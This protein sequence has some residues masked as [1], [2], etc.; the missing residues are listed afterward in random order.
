VLASSELKKKKIKN[1]GGRIS[2]L[3]MPQNERRL[4]GWEN[5]FFLHHQCQ[6][7]NKHLCQLSILCVVVVVVVVAAV[8]EQQQV[9]QYI[10]HRRCISQSDLPRPSWE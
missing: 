4:D 2:G 7:P 8:T 1:R 9:Q 10:L 6:P 5:L 3:A